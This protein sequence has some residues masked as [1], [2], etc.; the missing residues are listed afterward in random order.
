MEVIESRRWKAA[1]GQTASIYGALPYVSESQRIAEGW[2]IE[3]T[4]YTIRWDNGTV[5]ASGLP[6][7]STREAAE[8][9]VARETA[10]LADCRARVLS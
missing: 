3:S 1:N 4:G 7:G 10:R 5:G 2:A 9:F 6:F 8:A